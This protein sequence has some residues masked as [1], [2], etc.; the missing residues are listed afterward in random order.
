MI[1]NDKIIQA[2]SFKTERDLVVVNLL[3]ASLV[4]VI[5]FFPNSP[6]R[7]ILGLSFI[8]FFPG[9][10]LICALFPREKDLEIVER[11]A[12]SLGLSIAV[13]PLMG[14]A[15]N[16]TPF[17]I[18]CY[19]VTFSLFLFIVLMSAVAIY[20][21]RIISPK[22]AFAP[23]A[24]LSISGWFERVKNKFI[25]SNDENRIIKIIAII[26][27]IFVIFALTIIAKTPP[28]S[29]YEISIYDAYPWYFWVFIIAAIAC[30][31]CILLHQAFA[32][33]RSN[34]WLIGLFAII[35]VNTIILLLPEFRGY[36]FY[37]RGDTCSHLGYIRD[38]LNTGH[39]GERNFYPV[40][41]I[42]GASL[43]Q[44]GGVSLDNIPSL[45]FVLFSWIYIA[46]MYLLAKSMGKHS[47]QVLVI[48]ALASVLIYSFFHVNIHSN[49]F[50]LFMVPCLLY[51]Y[52]KR[53]LFSSNRMGNTILLLLM[54]LCI[55]FFHPVTTL[56][57]IIIFFTFGLAYVLYSHFISP[58]TSELGQHSTVGKNFLGISIIM[59]IFFFLWYLSYA[60][61]CKSFKRVADWLLYQLGDPL[62]EAQ[63][64]PLKKAMLT[65]FQIFE[66]FLNMYGAIFLMLLISSIAFIYVL[67]KSLSRKH[68]MQPMMF[69]YAI[70]FMIAFFIGATMLL[71]FFIE[72]N[73][74]RVARLLL[75][76]G[77]ILSGLVVY[78]FIEGCAKSNPDSRNKSLR[79]LIYI[80]VII[81]V[82]IAMAALS[83]GSVYNSQRTCKPNAQVTQM[84][85]VGTEWFER[86]KSF[87]IPVVVN[88]AGIRRF[89][90]YIFGTTTS[91]IT[92]ARI[93]SERLPSHFGYDVNNTVAEALAFQDRYIVTVELDKVAPLFFPENVRAKCHQ[94]TEED[95][96]KLKTDPTVGQ[97]YNNG[98]FEV[99]R[100]Y[101][102]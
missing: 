18:R 63:L 17:G 36:V 61:I 6:I 87:D 82:I 40:E 95:F 20:R 78:E 11:L 38:I 47:G 16:Y 28:A 91:S 29:G 85:L 48:I 35:F 94:F 55:V 66:L 99:W 22:D 77:T 70:Q 89:R 13:T 23:L 88:T 65:P 21:R 68:N 53:E 67:R 97:I 50:S 25:K 84:E 75:L 57:V 79:R 19:P 8:L 76:M 15:L 45:F 42:L 62:I 27:F 2:L 43:I 92:R 86:S 12:L 30:G 44:V 41:H 7:I 54:A 33:K 31:I 81:I 100:V 73:P 24:S 52:H 4:A 96:A 80:I 26:A 90:D 64:E 46:N 49:I 72:Y 9:Y 10:V 39:V 58:V 3:S 1:I 32:E 74:V 101:G 102:Q 56:L 34:W 60:S 51:L 14:L 59:L 5:T 69:T 93:D 37:G 71:G 98:E 83:L